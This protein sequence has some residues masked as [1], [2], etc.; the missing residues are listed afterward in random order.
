MIPLLQ[1]NFILFESRSSDELAYMPV[2][3]TL[4]KPCDEVVEST[5][6]WM[7][8]IV[9]D[10]TKEFDFLFALNSAAVHCFFKEPLKK[11]SITLM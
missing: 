4:G 7:D 10:Q 11:L 3:L 1:G 2:V 9:W 6:L 5:P 8:K